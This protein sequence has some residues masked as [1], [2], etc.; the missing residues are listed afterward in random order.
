MLTLTEY[1]F[2]GLHTAEQYNIYMNINSHFNNQTSNESQHI[3]NE[4]CIREQI[5]LLY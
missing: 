5:E 4:T 3:T 1:Q 2:S